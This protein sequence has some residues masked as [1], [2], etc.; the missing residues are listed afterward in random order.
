MR[1]LEDEINPK[2]FVMKYDR[3][4]SGLNYE[5]RECDDWILNGSHRYQYIVFEYGKKY[6]LTNFN[7]RYTLGHEI[8][9]GDITKGELILGKCQFFLK[10]IKFWKVHEYVMFRN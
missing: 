8:I 6:L 10:G 7:Q 4:P 2:P 3:Y 1:T 5:M 9:G